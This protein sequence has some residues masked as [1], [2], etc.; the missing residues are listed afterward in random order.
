MFTLQDWFN[1]RSILGGEF[2]DVHRVYVPVL[3]KMQAFAQTKWTSPPILRAF[4]TLHAAKAGFPS[5][6]AIRKALPLTVSLAR[7][8]WG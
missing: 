7:R 3:F 4:Y 6:M 5:G 1:M 8:A 2:F